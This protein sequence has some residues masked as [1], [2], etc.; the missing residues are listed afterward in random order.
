MKKILLT[1]L[2]FS[3]TVTVSGQQL[4]KEALLSL[5]AKETC[6]C[7]QSKKEKIVDENKL[8][9]ETGFCIIASY[10][11]HSE[12]AKTVFGPIFE[13]T[14]KAEKL[15]EEVAMK[16]ITVCPDTFKTLVETFMTE[17]A[18]ADEKASE[19]FTPSVSGKVVEVKT[20]D[21]ITLV[22]ADASGRKHSL[23]LLMPFEGANL[24]IENKLKKSQSVEA[25]YFEQEFYDPKTKDYKYFKVLDFLELK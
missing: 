24:L 7:L 8:K 12:E 17:E 23:L 5:M 3:G 6:E 19:V 11:K 21:F 10:T 16:M 25:R 13:D 4:D 18:A 22:I 9:A 14:K 15:G 2:I 1:A 20:G